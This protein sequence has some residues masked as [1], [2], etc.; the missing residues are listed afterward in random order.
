MRGWN[1]VV[2][3]LPL[4]SLLIGVVVGGVLNIFNQNFYFK[5]FKANNNR[6]IARLSPMMIGSVTFS[7]GMFVFG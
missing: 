1:Q 3:S 2:G 4:L 7:T 6:P 5:R